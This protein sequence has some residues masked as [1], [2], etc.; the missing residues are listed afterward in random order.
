MNNKHTLL[1]IFLMLF[2][3]SVL[4][5]VGPFVDNGDGTV[6][7]SSRNLRWQK[8]TSGQ[9]NDSSCS[10]TA[11]TLTWQNALL[12][13]KNLTLASKTWRLPNRNELLSLVDYSAYMPAIKSS[14]F[15]NTQSGNYWTSTTYFGFI[16]SAWIITFTQGKLDIAQKVGLDYVRCV[17]AGP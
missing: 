10:G 7:D 4:V 13:C 8:C 1:F 6:T 17:T 16:D 9:T 14:A 12:Y 11:S 5:A 15:P 2:A 3:S